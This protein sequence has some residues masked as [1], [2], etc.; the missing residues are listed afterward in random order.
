V[1]L[2]SQQ[3]VGAGLGERQ[4]DDGWKDSEEEVVARLPNVRWDRV[5]MWTPYESTGCVLRVGMQ[6]WKTGWA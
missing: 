4:Y 2:D 5:L 6:T 3:V 1:H